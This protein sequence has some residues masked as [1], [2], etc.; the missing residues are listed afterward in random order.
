[1]RI[2]KDKDGFTLIE[3][4]VVVTVLG[5]IVVL[6]TEILFTI[7]RSANKSRLTTDAKQNGEYALAV[8]SKMIRNAKTVTCDSS[9]GTASEITILNPDFNSTTFEFV[10]DPLVD[11][12]RVASSSAGVREYLTSSKVTIPAGT[13]S[14]ECIPSILPS[15][16]VDGYPDTIIINFQLTTVGNYREEEKINL[17]FKTTVITRNY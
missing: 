7:V 10:T 11:N 4:L 17:T 13:A 12:V 3:M 6:V 8:M 9:S 16:H 2:K 1:M 5:V 14:F 15:N